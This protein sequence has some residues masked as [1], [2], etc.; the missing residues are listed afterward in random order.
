MRTTQQTVPRSTK[1]F[2]IR[3]QRES[4]TEE[5]I[6]QLLYWNKQRSFCKYTYKL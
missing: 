2:L 3:K 4:L 1:E 6:Q 5:K